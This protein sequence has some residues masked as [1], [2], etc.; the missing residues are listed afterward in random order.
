M[1]VIAPQ[2]E[3]RSMLSES[4]APA[5]SIFVPTHRAGKEIR[6]NPIRLKNLVK[7]AEDQLVK[8]GTRPAR[9]AHA[10]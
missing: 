2:A 7:Q 6:Q 5:V 9:G 1:P 8:E 4:E 10:S 3:I